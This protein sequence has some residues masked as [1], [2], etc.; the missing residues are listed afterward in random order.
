MKAL[1]VGIQ[2][3]S[4]LRERSYLYVDKTEKLLELIYKGER[5][6]LP[7]TRRFGKSLTLSTLES[8]FMGESELFK[9]LAAEEWVIE[10]SKNP[11][12]VI[13]FDVSSLGR[14]SNGEELN[15]SM[16]LGL[17]EVVED[18]NLQLETEA[19]SD[20]MLR[21][22]IRALYKTAGSVVVLIDEYDKPILDNTDNIEKANEMREVL[23]SFYSTL[24]SCDKY[25]RFV[26]LTGISRFS[27]AG[28]FSAMNNPED[29]SMDEDFGDITGCTQSEL[30][31]YF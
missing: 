13:R 7:R 23:R 25:L 5:Y 12:P 27:K 6:F 9:G 18:N 20:D 30:E 19:K 14:Y 22:I 21:R 10:Q 28:V 15:L 11:S 16:I 26:M 8:M 24:K 2:S 29:I 31:F 1:P 4:S 17:E 3:F